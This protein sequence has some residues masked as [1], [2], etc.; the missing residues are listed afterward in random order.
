MSSATG[1]LVWAGG[2][3][4]GPGEATVPALDHGL[5]VGDGV[6]ETCKVSDGVPFALTRHLRRLARSAS[7]L[8][9]TAPDE[10]AVRGAVADVLAARHLGFG[11]L[12]ITWTGGPGPLGSNRTPGAGTLVVAA[13]EVPR[14]AAGVGAVRVPFVRN[15]RA[16]TVGLK[17]TSYAENVVA[18]AY[19]VERGG[20]EAL[21]GN[22]R[23]ELCEGTGSNVVVVVGDELV[24]PPLSSGCLAGITRELLLAWAAD[25][26]LPVAER[27]LPLAVLDDA[28][29]VL[30]TSST[31][32]VQ[33][34]A[35]VDGRRLASGELSRAA[36]ELFARRS[37]QDPDPL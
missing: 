31:R 17:T 19:A 18:L 13:D 20:S 6:F 27:D 4:Q 22:S 15:E 9:L 28:A 11:R 14:W 24:T 21:L 8:G 25:E 16:A 23:E 7:G 30:L 32:D 29:Q 37:G 3:V 33:A 2:R 10:Q 5:T 34:L 26:G 1:P 35:H 36:V 12:R